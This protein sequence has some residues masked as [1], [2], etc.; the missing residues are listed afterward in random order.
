MMFTVVVSVP[1][2]SMVAKLLTLHATVMG[3]CRA[4]TVALQ[5]SFCFAFGVGHG[6]GLLD[7]APHNGIMEVVQAHRKRLAHLYILG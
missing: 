4:A 1:E 2:V 6:C 5:S 3:F 7:H